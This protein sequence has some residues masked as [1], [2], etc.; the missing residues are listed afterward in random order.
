MGAVLA[1]ARL[2]PPSSIAD[3]AAEAP[4]LTRC[5]SASS[6]TT[7]W[8]G[9]WSGTLVRG[10][11]EDDGG[12]T[13]DRLIGGAVDEDGRATADGLTAGRAAMVF[14]RKA[15]R[16]G[17]SSSSLSSSDEV[18]VRSMRLAGIAAVPES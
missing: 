7:A 3:M 6:D 10:T 5:R 14:L 13:A 12:A 4:S 18:S 2:G 17:N 11:A 8:T 15:F 1:G 9:R 16:M